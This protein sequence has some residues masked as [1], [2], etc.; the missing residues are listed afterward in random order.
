MA[1]RADAEQRG[2]RRSRPRLRARGAMLG[3]R[4]GRP[5]SRSLAA[6]PSS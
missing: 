4:V 5:G 3:S 1:D 2:S 6:R